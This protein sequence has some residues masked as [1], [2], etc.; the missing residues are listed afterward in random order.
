MAATTKALYFAGEG[1]WAVNIPLAPVPAARPRVSRWGTYYP[2]T[3]RTWIAEAGAL[4]MPLKK[5][6]VITEESVSVVVH[7]VARRPANPVRG[8]PRGDVDNYTKAALDIV[9]KS[10]LIW[11]DDTQVT[12]LLSTKRYVND[13]EEPYTYIWATLEG[14]RPFGSQ[15]GEDVYDLPE[16]ARI[17]GGR[18]KRLAEEQ[19]VR[20]FQKAG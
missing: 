12:V 4:L 6:A 8:Y 13:D 20:D 3:Y 7:S 14:E 17:S 11:K 16:E 10:Q 9:T 18:G 19:M 5:R 15:I 1:E 2:K